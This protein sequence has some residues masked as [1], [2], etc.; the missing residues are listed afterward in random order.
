MTSPPPGSGTPAAEWVVSSGPEQRRKLSY[1]PDVE[2]R[3][4]IMEQCCEAWSS[5]DFAWQEHIAAYRAQ[6]AGY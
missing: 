5:I 4:Q 6:V 2:T 1:E 3:V